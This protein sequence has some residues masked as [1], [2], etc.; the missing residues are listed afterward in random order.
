MN[1]RRAIK[2]Q[3]ATIPKLNPSRV[4]VLVGDLGMIVAVLSTGSDHIIAAGVMEVAQLSKLRERPVTNLRYEL[5]QS[6]KR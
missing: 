2:S 1:Q 4:R 3:S 6:V 5:S